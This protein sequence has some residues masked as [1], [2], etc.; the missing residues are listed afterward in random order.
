MRFALSTR[1]AQELCPTMR[2]SRDPPRP[3]HTLR[4]RAPGPTF[5]EYV[6]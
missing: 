2:A 3:T 4:D 1:V 5:Q 6:S